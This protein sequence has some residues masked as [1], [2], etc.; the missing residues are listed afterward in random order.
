VANWDRSNWPPHIHPPREAEVS[1]PR[2]IVVDPLFPGT[3]REKVLCACLLDLVQAEP[4]LTEEQNLDKLILAMQS[5]RCRVFLSGDDQNDFDH[6][7][8]SVS[9]ELIANADGQPPWRLLLSSL[10][11]NGALSTSGDR[12][13]PG[14]RFDDVRSSLPDLDSTFLSLVAK[15]AE[16][17][18]ELTELDEPS[19]TTQPVIEEIQQQHAALQSGTED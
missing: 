15:A 10:T 6:S 11:A 3:D 12:I 14:D 16:R 1:K 19:E 7:L 5:Q 4:E 17:Y 18:R 9:N 13:E 2:P 8:E